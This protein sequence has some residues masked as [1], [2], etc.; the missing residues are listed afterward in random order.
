MQCDAGFL[1]WW[2]RERKALSTSRHPYILRE[3]Q[4]WEYVITSL[5]IYPFSELL[6]V[7]SSVKL[8]IIF[9]KDV[10]LLFRCTNEYWTYG[11]SFYSITTR[12]MD[13][14]MTWHLL[15]KF[16]TQRPY[17]LIYFWHR[18]FLLKV[19]TIRESRTSIYF[20]TICLWPLHE[21]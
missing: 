19:F 20:H 5:E 3:Q 17:I 16:Y 15:R 18:K 4:W 11:F 2:N 10:R 6:L 12:M 1:Y 9:R 8:S 13:H 21:S 7:E 14:I